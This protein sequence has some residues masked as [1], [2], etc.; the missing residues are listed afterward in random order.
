MLVAHKGGEGAKHWRV[1]NNLGLARAV[2]NRQQLLQLRVLQVCNAKGLWA[3]RWGGA[4]WTTGD[5]RAVKKCPDQTSI[6]PPR[7][8]FFPDFCLSPR[9]FLP[10]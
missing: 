3:I 1:E 4:A 6:T 8:F 2:H 9:F 10:V 5:E 7:F